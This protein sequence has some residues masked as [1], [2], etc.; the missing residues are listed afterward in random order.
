MNTGIKDSE[1][2]KKVADKIV[3]NCKCLEPSFDRECVCIPDYCNDINA[4]WKIVE[5]G[6]KDYWMNLHKIKN[7]WDCTLISEVNFPENRP[8]YLNTEGNSS[9]AKAICIAFL[10]LKA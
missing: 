9:A 10:K 1:I 6:F 4:A 8:Q 5:F 3:H 2:N 7:V